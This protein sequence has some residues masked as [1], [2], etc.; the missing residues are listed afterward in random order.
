[1]KVASQRPR[2]R[3]FRLSLVVALSI[4][5]VSC[6]IATNDVYNTPSGVPLVVA[7]P[8]V[9]ANDISTANEPLTAEYVL[10]SGP[11]N[12]TLKCT[13]DAALKLCPDGSFTYTSNA[14]FVGTDTFMYKAKDTGGSGNEG[15]VS[16]AVSSGPATAGQLIISEFR[17]SGPGGVGDE[18]VEIYNTTNFPHT[19][20]PSDTSSGYALAT[21]DGVV[22]FTIPMFTVIPARGH[23][24]ATNSTGYSLNDYPA[25]TDRGATGDVPYATDIPINTGIALF[26]TANPANFTQETRLDAA[27]PT[28][29]A[30]TLYREGAGY[31]AINA[32]TATNY[33]IVRDLRSGLPKDTNNNDADFDAVDPAA[34]SLCVGTTN[35]QCQRVGDPGPENTSSPTQRNADIK[36]SLVD[37]GCTG[38]IV[39]PALPSAC[40]FERNT[41]PVAAAPLG[42][43][44]IRRKFTNTNPTQSVTRLR[45]RIVDITTAPEA[46][47]NN[48]TADLRVLSSPTVTATC[49]NES[50]TTH[51]CSDNPGTTTE[52][53]GLTY[54]G[55]SASGGGFN[56]SVASG[57]ITPSAALIP[58]ESINIQFTLGVVQNGR[59]RFF[60]NVEASNSV[61]FDDAISPTK[62]QATRNGRRRKG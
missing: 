55:T 25:G 9:L 48:G 21:S 10:G 3:R 19:V 61:P 47:G 28:T 34:T 18:F 12:G 20:T 56:S 24:L 1:M 44:S 4:L 39:N 54:E 35:F 38:M 8:G 50:G 26:N 62:A 23:F 2:A 29:E 45:F 33:S 58:G 31:P 15:T 32:A 16:I 22:R 49:Q 43:I 36:A 57:S 42:T 60:V 51:V 5:A 13:T 6:G 59:F 53:E 17:L 30:N 14:G 40:R 27:G 41:T 52:I 37:T 46:I 11:S 7:A